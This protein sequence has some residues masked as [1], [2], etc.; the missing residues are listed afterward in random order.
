[1]FAP[2]NNAYTTSLGGGYTATF[3]GTS[4]ASP[5][6]AGDAACIQ[7]AAKV[8]MGSFLT[9]DQIQSKMIAA[10]DPITYAAAG[11]TKPLVNLGNVDLVPVPAMNISTLLIVMI[12]IPIISLTTSKKA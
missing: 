7:S 11:I 6:A 4:A 3:G 8:I 9:P 5:Y 12:M 1:M 10:G 2:S